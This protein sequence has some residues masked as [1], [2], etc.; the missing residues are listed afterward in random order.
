MMPPRS[1]CRWVWVAPRDR[2]TLPDG[3][4]EWDLR[5]DVEW[6]DFVDEIV[7]QVVDYR[8]AILRGHDEESYPIG[9]LVDARTI[10]RDEAEAY[11]V[12]IP[13][14]HP[15]EMLIGLAWLTDRS[16][17]DAYDEGRFGFMS[18]SFNPSGRD[19]TGR[20]WTYRLR[21]LSQTPTPWVKRQPAAALLAALTMS[22]TGGRQMTIQDFAAELAALL[23]AEALDTEALRELAGRMAA[24]AEASME[25]PEEERTAPEALPP[26]S[27][28]GLS[29]RLAGAE[30]RLAMSEKLAAGHA[31]RVKELEAIIRKRDAADRVTRDTASLSLSD[32]VRAGLV[33]LA[34][35]DDAGYRVALS[36]AS[37]AAPP[38]GQTR[39]AAGH[40]PGRAAVSLSEALA[41][42]AMRSKI[43]R[44]RD[45]EKART[46]TRPT[47][48]AALAAVLGG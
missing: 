8:P 1:E 5:G 10:T 33:S 37:L 41:D 2:I 31:K 48:E 19:S 15:G 28:P 43:A 6:A 42:P 24:A 39:D 32:E 38:T 23:S 4:G 20:K 36:C 29:V 26:M 16:A 11:G 3:A 18:P 22:D 46:G 21:E 27:D 34:E 44:W 47:H 25:E 45:A 35:R 13:P 12:H 30:K 9:H 14:G 40:E 7:R 17:R